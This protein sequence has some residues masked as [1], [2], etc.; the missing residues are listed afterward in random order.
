MGHTSASIF[1]DLSKAFDT[2]NHQVLLK[3]LDCYG[4]RGIT[5]DW[6]KSYF[7]ERSLRAKISMSTNNTVHSEKF[8][9]TYGSAQGSCLGLLL[10]ILFCNNIH[11]IPLYGHF[12]LFA[13]DMTLFNH[14]Q[15]R[16]F[17]NYMMTHDNNLLSG[18]R[19]TNYCST[20]VKQLQ[21]YSGLGITH[22]VS[23]LMVKSFLK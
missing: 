12:I 21:C 14:H 13:D 23:P 16:N 3:K 2:L 18:S 17:L 20:C 11:L 10:F 19:L 22:S 15:N 5:N 9:I 1:L 4:I 8:N 6:F 7:S